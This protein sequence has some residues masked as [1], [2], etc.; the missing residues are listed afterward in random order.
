MKKEI[1]KNDVYIYKEPTEKKP[2]KVVIF[3]TGCALM[4]HVAS[5]KNFDQFKKFLK[6]FQ[7]KIIYVD[8]YNKGTSREVKHY[9]TNYLIKDDVCGFWKPQRLS[10]NRKKIKALSNGSIVDCILKR[11]EKN[12]IITICRPNPN[13]KEVYKPYTT[14]QH[15]EHCK[16]YGTY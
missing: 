16:T 5:F 3:Q 15:I 4:F 11:D 8:T 9:K 7:I 14:E 12:K 10:K 13:A 6:I 2:Y 1:K